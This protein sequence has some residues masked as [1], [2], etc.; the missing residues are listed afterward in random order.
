M[1]APMRVVIG[2]DDVLM[3]EGIVRVLSE[4]G[5]DIVG[6]AGDADA[7]LRKALAHRRRCG[8]RRHP[9]AAGS[10]RRWPSGGA[11][12]ASAAP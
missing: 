7:F 9:D 10:R 5:F 11:R 1:S 2:E 6:Q 12:A 8:C 3:R 4:A